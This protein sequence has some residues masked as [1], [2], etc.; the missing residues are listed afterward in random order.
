MMGQ[1]NRISNHLQ[2]GKAVINLLDS[3]VKIKIFQRFLTPFL[4]IDKVH[5]KEMVLANNKALRVK[6]LN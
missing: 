5:I 2:D 3:T 6:I 1:K 4:L